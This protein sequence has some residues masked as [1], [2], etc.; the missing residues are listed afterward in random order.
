M[1][2]VM[3]FPRVVTG[4]SFGIDE[5]TLGPSFRARQIVNSERYMLLDRKQS[6]YSCT[7]HDWKQYDFDGRAIP[8]GNPLLGQPALA[9][10]PSDWY[11][12]LRMRR[13]TAPYRLART[14]VDSFTN[15]V[16]GYQRWP[17]IRCPED[18]NTEAFA[19][20]LANEAGM[21]TLMIRAR[22]IGGCI[23][24]V[25][26]SWRFYKG[27]PVVQVHNPKHIYVHAWVDREL[28]IPAHVM[29]VYR[30][31]R[32]EWD[33]L[34]QGYVR[35]WYWFRRDW[36]PVADVAFFEQRYDP[37]TDPQ[38]VID[39]AN[40][41]MHR[42][43]FAHFVWGQNMPNEAPEEIDGVPDYEGL[44]ETF[45]A[46]DML[47]STLARGTTLNLDPTLVLKLDPDLIARGGV[48]K[49]SD[50]AL[51]VGTN[52][53]AKYMEIQ[54]TSVQAGTSLF[55]K[56]RE[57]ALEA[58]QCVVPDPNQIGAAGTSSIA[59]KVVYAP[60]LGKADILREQYE[61]MI[62]RLLVQM[63][64]SARNIVGDVDVTIDDEGNSVAQTFFI[65]LPPTL[66]TTEDLDP[67]GAPT[68]RYTTTRI[69]LSPGVSDQLTFDWGDY[70]LPTAQDQQQLATTLGQAVT[71]GILSKEAAADTMARVLRIDPRADWA[72]IQREA[73]QRTLSQE[74]MFD[75][76]GAAGRVDRPN[77][78]PPG[79]S[80]RGARGPHVDLMKVDEVRESLGL[81]PLGAPEG[82]M[83]VAEYQAFLRARE[84]V[85]HENAK[86]AAA[87]P[88][89]APEARLSADLE[90]DGAPEGDPP[91]PG[92]PARP[93]PIPV[94][95]P[96]G[97]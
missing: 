21:R 20:A 26:L 55:V 33:P 75:E 85:A 87:A 43:G 18:P 31:H 11:V 16:F 42:D 8:K 37:G 7:Q 1:A 17:T 13:P 96:N 34:K 67:Y 92:A 72:R 49:G 58:A 29:E 24:S 71:A 95:D 91:L 27:K 74:A 25:G 4:S 78:L 28:L 6:Y 3:P 77:A 47:Y 48:R 59:L 57:S 52:G 79:A 5:T 63:L 32:D 50:N 36:T 53:D 51:T 89:Q 61:G 69:E 60:M 83:T 66:S 10:A 64:R 94:P 12:P 82:D 97:G 70:F 19:R 86:A 44:Y 80:A 2:Q 81:P 65:D 30:Y 9:S 73:Q 45:D 68:G 39:E 88:P 14:I 22:T 35:N 56:M 46:L 54:G 90:G 38:W 84:K 40:T 41:Y 23:G 76:P 62:G 93:A 15:L